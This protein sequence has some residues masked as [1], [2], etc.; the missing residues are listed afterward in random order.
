MNQEKLEA[1]RAAIVKVVPE[2]MELKHGCF[3]SVNGEE[4]FI[5]STGEIPAD[6]FENGDV[7]I[8]GRTIRLA[9]VL[10]AL[11]AK[12]NNALATYS[13]DTL[14]HLRDII[15]ERYFWTSDGMIPII[16]NLR[17]D[18]L[19]AQSPECIDFVY[20]IFVV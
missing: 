5:F 11:G 14:G 19:T 9:D 4:P 18:D 13:V 10:L 7:Q 12:T 20:D 6:A 16:W 17:N 2:I 1:V 3:V 8:L 15:H